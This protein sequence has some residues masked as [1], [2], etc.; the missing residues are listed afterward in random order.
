MQI[1]YDRD[2]GVQLCRQLGA[3]MQ[4]LKVEVGRR[5]AYPLATE[6]E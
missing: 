6:D 3:G 2:N 4:E 5:Q 1:M